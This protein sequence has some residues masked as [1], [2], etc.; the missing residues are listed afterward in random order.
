MEVILIC[1]S[2][3]M[4][5]MTQTQL[6]E[7]RVCLADRFIIQERHVR[8]SRRNLG[9]GTEAE[10]IFLFKECTS[11][12]SLRYWPICPKVGPSHLCSLSGKWH[13][14]MSTG[15]SDEGNF[16]IEASRVLGT[17]TAQITE[18]Q[19]TESQLRICE[20]PFKLCSETTSF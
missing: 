13:I 20:E 18:S 11:C 12:N 1:F 19:I 10:I 15:Q 7:E 3:V 14:H 9:A 8:R 6:E 2:V 4:P 5:T 16:S 17:D